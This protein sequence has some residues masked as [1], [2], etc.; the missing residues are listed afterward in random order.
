[1]RELNYREEKSNKLKQPRHIFFDSSCLTIQIAQVLSESNELPSHTMYNI[2]M[3]FGHAMEAILFAALNSKRVHVNDCFF[4]SLAMYSP[5]SCCAY[6]YIYD[7][8]VPIK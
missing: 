4:L 8:G 3:K 7:Q 1:V 5:C 6:K 2:T